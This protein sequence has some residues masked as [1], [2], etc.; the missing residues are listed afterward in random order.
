MHA[1]R[2]SE[3][4]DLGRLT[5]WAGMA[6]IILGFAGMVATFPFIYGDPAPGQD[7]TDPTWFGPVGTGLVVALGAGVVLIGASLIHWLV[8]HRTGRT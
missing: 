8:L 2:M 7:A 4:G 6:L 3:R 1:G 5:R